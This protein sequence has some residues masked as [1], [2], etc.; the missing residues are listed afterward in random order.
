[1]KKNLGLQLNQGLLNV[2]EELRE[3]NIKMFY[4]LSDNYSSATEFFLDVKVSIQGYNKS[5]TSVVNSSDEAITVV[6]KLVNELREYK[7]RMEIQDVANEQLRLAEDKFSMVRQIVSVF[8]KKFEICIQYDLMGMLELKR[9]N[10]KTITCEDSTGQKVYL[11]ENGFNKLYSD[12][13]IR[14]YAR[15]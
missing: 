7:G 6:K 4:S 2:S 10:R 8:A 9:V 5:I 3:K 14:L 11:D 12:D 15:D 1:M 13:L